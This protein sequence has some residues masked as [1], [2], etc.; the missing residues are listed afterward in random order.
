VK[1]RKEEKKRTMQVGGSRNAEVRSSRISFLFSFFFSFL[2]FSFLCVSCTHL[3]HEPIKRREHPRH[4]PVGFATAQQPAKIQANNKTRYRAA[5]IGIGMMILFLYD[6]DFRN[7]PNNVGNPE[8]EE[9][10]GTI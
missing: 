9:D 10:E 6:R 2:F 8:K 4:I 1:K 7:I 5:A 3:E